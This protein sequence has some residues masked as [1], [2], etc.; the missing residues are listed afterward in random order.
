MRA[1][2][3]LLVMRPRVQLA[4][5][6]QILRGLQEFLQTNS[7]ILARWPTGYWRV[8]LLLVQTAGAARLLP[9]KYLDRLLHILESDQVP[10]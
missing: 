1:L 8:L 7:T 10:V 2:A 4:L 9:Q 6:S 3:L 5:S